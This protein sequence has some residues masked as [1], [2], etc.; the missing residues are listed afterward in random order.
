MNVNT[1]HFGYVCK[2]TGQWIVTDPVGLEEYRL[3]RIE[4]VAHLLTED[5]LMHLRANTPDKCLGVYMEDVHPSTRM[6]A[7]LSLL[8][9]MDTYDRMCGMKSEGPYLACF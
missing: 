6:G 4:E 2:Q 5:D 7:L 9:T 1:T 8:P 3:A